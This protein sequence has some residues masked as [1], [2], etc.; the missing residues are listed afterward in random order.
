MATVFMYA[1]CQQ[2]VAP[3]LPALVAGALVAVLVTH[4]AAQT[5]PPPAYARPEEVASLDGLLT[6]LGDPQNPP[7]YSPEDYVELSRLLATPCDQLEWLAAQARKLLTQ[8]PRRADA[9]RLA[10]AALTRGQTL[11]QRG[12]L[13]R[14]AAI[15]ALTELAGQSETLDSITDPDALRT[16]LEK[17]T[18]LTELAPAAKFVLLARGAPARQFFGRNV[19]ESWDVPRQLVDRLAARPDLPPFADLLDWQQRLSTA[20]EQWQTTAATAFPDSARQQHVAASF[21]IAAALLDRALGVE[22]GAARPERALAYPGDPAAWTKLATD[23]AADAVRTWAALAHLLA[24][25]SGGDPATSAAAAQTVWADVRKVSPTIW[26]ALDDAAAGW[27][28]RCVAAERQLVARQLP[29]ARSYAG[30]GREARAAL[31]TRI[32]TLAG[33]S[34]ASP[35][36][37]LQAIQRAKAAD[38]GVGDATATLDDLKRE[39]EAQLVYLFVEI[40]ALGP[41]QSGQPSAYCG[42]AL[43]RTRYEEKM[44]GVEYR[45]EWA[46]KILRPT[47]SVRAV[48]ADAL[49]APGPPLR[50]GG[51]IR[52]DARILLA[53]DGPP[54]ADWFD[55]ESST[56]LQATEWSVTPS[57]IVYL[58]SAA[59]LKSNQWNLDT[60][61]RGWYRAALQRGSAPPALSTPPQTLATGLGG[62]PLTRTDMLLYVV[63]FAGRKGGNEN[64]IADF[65]EAKRRGKL[66]ALALWVDK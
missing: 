46:T 53:L 29:L 27:L 50:E 23:C 33:D 61:L 64:K 42:V 38:L 28:T 58:P 13:E 51:Q 14:C 37:L 21:Q 12:L 60:V 56:L 9:A 26:P 18:N 31:E 66:T 49:A 11:T 55:Y 32:R 40:C 30:T 35:D 25:C 5:P 47:D 7:A 65:M 8:P 36:E 1:S 39:F 10:R 19:S 24:A 48:L 17:A 62:A 59:A 41:A 54:P 63:N 15:A 57:W 43:Y 52:K 20:A 3:R 22:A 4:A 16:R 45:D 44:A 6:N 34:G 2:L